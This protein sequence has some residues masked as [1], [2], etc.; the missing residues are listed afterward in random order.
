MNTNE[1]VQAI[2]ERREFFGIDGMTKGDI[3]SVLVAQAYVVSMYLEGNLAPNVGLRATLPGLGKLYV[4]ERAARTGRNPAT[5]EAV[6]ISARRVVKF[7]PAKEFAERV[8]SD[9]D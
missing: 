4:A 6:E 1:L 8:D 3:K 7:R 9:D 2:Y 5:G